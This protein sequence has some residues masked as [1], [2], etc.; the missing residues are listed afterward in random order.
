MMEP[1]RDRLVF[2]DVLRAIA[3]LCVLA[4]H[5]LASVYGYGFIPWSG[6]LRNFSGQ[7][8]DVRLL[9]PISFGQL[10]VAVFFVISGFCI[11]MTFSKGRNWREFYLRRFFRLYPAYLAALA[12][13]VVLTYPKAIGQLL[14]QP[15]YVWSAA[16]HAFLCHNFWSADFKSI[17]PA[18]WSLAIEA[19]LY[20]LYPVMLWLIRKVEWCGMLMILAVIEVSIQGL[21]Q[22]YPCSFTDFLVRTPFGYWFSWALGSMLAD[23]YLCEDTDRPNAFWYALALAVAT[24]FIKPLGFMWFT[25]WALTAAAAIGNVL[26]GHWTGHSVRWLALPLAEVGKWSYSLYLLHMPLIVI[27]INAAFYLKWI[28]QG[29]TKLEVLWFGVMSWI[30]LIPLSCLWYNVFERPWIEIG[31]FV[32]KQK[33]SVLKCILVCFITLASIIALIVTQSKMQP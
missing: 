33:I 8:W 29:S 7:P 28:G 18:Y 26:S 10:G 12:L 13:F 19:Q 24:Y 6:E 25:L 23:D 20:M 11:H 17:N 27:F 22:Q 1:S 9:F 14:A 4:C 31:G 21:G 15:W 3:V 2:L 30:V 16:R 32:I 5:T